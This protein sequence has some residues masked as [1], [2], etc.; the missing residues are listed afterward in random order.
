M[1]LKKDKRQETLTYLV[2]W[3]LLFM[4]PVLSLH[5][6][7]ASDSSLTFD[8][9]EVLMVWKQYGL[10]FAIFLIHNH[11]L[12]PLLVENHKRTLYFSITTL[13]IGLFAFYQFS[14]HPDGLRGH[15][16]GEEMT[17]EG[18]RPPEFED[19]RPPEFEGFR[20]PEF[21]GEHH[22]PQR[23][24]GIKRLED[25]R[26]PL[27]VGQHDII[28]V[29]MLVLML[30]M[31]LG[32]KLYFRQLRDQQRWANLERKNLEQRLEYLKYQLNPHF[33]MN[34]LNNIHALVDIDSERSKEAII[35]LSKILRYVL[36]ESN[37]ERVPMN[38]EIEFMHNYTQLMRMRYSDKLRFSVNI[39]DEGTGVYIPPLLFISFVENAFKHGVSYREESF[40]EIGGKRYKGR[41]GEERLLWTCCNSKHQKSETVGIPRQGGV[42]MANVR[43][44]LDLIFGN[45]YTLGTNETDNTYEVILDI[46]LGMSD[47]SMPKQTPQNHD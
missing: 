20:P 37:H 44:R 24:D 10:F 30:G 40:I 27:M 8:W 14:T 35:Q 28:A 29:V 11:L 15:R 18:H 26:P 19:H 3:G 12:A 4:A 41:Q 32:I 7:A 13:L 9:S 34:T 22:P 17:I 33:L 2:L 45:D 46:P 6:R 47:Y 25:R 43:Q 38:S 23:P 5:I 42:G 21:E 39:S 1:N 16:P 36:Y 31:N